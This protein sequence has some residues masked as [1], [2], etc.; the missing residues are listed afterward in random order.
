MYI[1][2]KRIWIGLFRG[3]LDLCC[4]LVTSLF[5]DLFELFDVYLLIC[6]LLSG[7]PI[8][9]SYSSIQCNVLPSVLIC[10]RLISYLFKWK[11]LCY[12][13]IN[14]YVCCSMVRTPSIPWREMT[15][16]EISTSSVS[17][18]DG[19]VEMDLWCGHICIFNRRLHVIDFPLR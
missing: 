12:K 3:M 18:I 7:F 17:T 6:R 2:I 14:P 8:V 5:I 10:F 13:L 11:I 1:L 19:S 9:L 4:C 16:T 15:C